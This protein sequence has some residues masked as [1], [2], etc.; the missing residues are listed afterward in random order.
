MMS[1]G[2]TACGFIAGDVWV[3]EDGK[4]PTMKHA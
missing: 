1:F 4:L 3:F 2:L